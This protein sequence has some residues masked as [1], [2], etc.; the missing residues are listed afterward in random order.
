MDAI[1]CSFWAQQHPYPCFLRLDYY[2]RSI[3]SYSGG[4]I[5]G[6]DLPVPNCWLP[7]EFFVLPGAL[8][9]FFTIISLVIVMNASSTLVVAFADVSK[10]GMLKW[11]ASSSPSSLDTYLL[12]SLSI[13]FPTSI[14]DTPD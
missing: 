5:D 8:L 6:S 13:L 3:G 4:W 10:N 12:L 14:F 2:S 7:A 9:R 11:A 1:C